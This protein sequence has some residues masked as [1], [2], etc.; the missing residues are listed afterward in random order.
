MEVARPSNNENF[1]WIFPSVG[2]TLSNMLEG[3][4]RYVTIYRVLHCPDIILNYD[5]WL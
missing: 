3:L 5:Y 2:K 1:C 4:S